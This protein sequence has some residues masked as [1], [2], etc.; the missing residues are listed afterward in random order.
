M[1]DVG[2]RLPQDTEG[3]PVAPP[4]ACPVCGSTRLTTTSRT[5][6][7]ATY[8]RCTS[9]GEIWNASRLESVSRGWPRYR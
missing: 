4:N 8:W 3:P 2:T 7:A 6:T 9:C 5:I 1:T